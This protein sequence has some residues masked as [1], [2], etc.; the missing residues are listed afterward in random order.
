MNYQYFGAMLFS[1][2]IFIILLAVFALF[3]YQRIKKIRYNPQ[4]TT[5]LFFACLG[6]FL[7]TIAFA[8]YFFEMDGA[9]YVQVTSANIVL[10]AF[11][12][13]YLHYEALATASPPFRRHGI[14]FSLLIASFTIL[15]LELGGILERSSVSPWNFLLF[16]LMGILIYGYAL[17][18]VYR[19][20]TLSKKRAVVFELA[21]VSFMFAGNALYFI[22]IIISIPLRLQFENLIFVFL[23]GIGI[24]FVGI[25]ILMFT[26]LLHPNYLYEVP[27][28]ILHI[29]LYNSIGI[30]VYSRSLKVPGENPLKIEKELLSGVFTA[31]SSLIKENLG[32]GSQLR[33]IDA[34]SYQIFFTQ[35]P[36]DSGSL[37][38]ITRKNT[39]FLQHSL[40]RFGTL[41]PEVL[42]KEIRSEI[43]SPQSIEKELD[44]ITK[45]AFPYVVFTDE[46]TKTHT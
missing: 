5:A 44:D 7:Q 41:F 40:K 21:S 15:L 4:F 32:R 3:V 35:L 10:I 33:H 8:M 39:F 31:I 9:F 6:F 22:V 24:V 12:F 38:I 1:T 29:M 36:E 23:M 43:I 13:L 17:T 46:E 45:K 11:Y 37:A 19:T 34:T 27:Y 14:I 18:V 28:P 30:L 20:F 26:Y 42:L 2:L 25:F 16:T